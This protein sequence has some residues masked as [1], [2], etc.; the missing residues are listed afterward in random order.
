MDTQGSVTHIAAIFK[1]GDVSGPRAKKWPKVNRG[2]KIVN[3]FTCMRHFFCMW[4]TPPEVDLNGYPRICN[5]YCRNSSNSEMLS[6]PRA[7]KWPKVNRGLKI[8]NYFTC[9]RHFFCMWYTPPE[10]DLNGYPRI[11]NPYCHNIQIQTCEWTQGKKMTQSK[12]RIKNSILFYMYADFFCRWYGPPEIDLNGYPRMSNPYCRD[13]QIQTCEWTQ[14]KKI[15]QIESRIKNSK[16][17]Y[18]YVALLR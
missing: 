17:F 6:G 4:Y 13:I 9:M 12:S 10:V 11:C 18:M 3:Y 1:F 8:V 7:K 5:P 14:G 2:L 16:L 15:A